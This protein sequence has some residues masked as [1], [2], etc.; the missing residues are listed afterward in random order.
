MKFD[1]EQEAID[2][3]QQV[4]RPKALTFLHDESQ[5]SYSDLID[6]GW[7]NKLLG[8][9]KVQLEYQLVNDI[10]VTKEIYYCNLYSESLRLYQ[11]LSYNCKFELSYINDD[12]VYFRRLS[13]HDVILFV[14][15]TKHPDLVQ[16]IK[17]ER[18]GLFSRLLGT[19]DM[20]PF[21]PIEDVRQWL[22]DYL[23]Y[24]AYLNS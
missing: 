16:V 18:A 8:I 20:V 7:E 13:D 3:V 21:N 6:L 5:V 19:Q 12:G 2:L 22:N 15:K 24:D 23:A 17:Q 4:V 11:K 1:N 14:D 10:E 9:R